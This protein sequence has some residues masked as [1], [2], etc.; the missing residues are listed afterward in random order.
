MFTF[1][2]LT[3]SNKQ[4][5][6]LL[7]GLKHGKKLEKSKLKADGRKAAPKTSHE[8]LNLGLGKAISDK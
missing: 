4:M 6:Y 8:L 2:I 1:S 7:W 3:D 5:E